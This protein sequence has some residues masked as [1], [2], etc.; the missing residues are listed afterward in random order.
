[1]R[2]FSKMERWKFEEIE[3]LYIVFHFQ[4]S[5]LPD[6][7]NFRYTFSKIAMTNPFISG[8]RLTFSAEYWTPPYYMRHNIYDNRYLIRHSKF[9]L[10]HDSASPILKTRKYFR[11][12]TLYK[13]F[14]NLARNKAPTTEGQA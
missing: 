3:F 5:I 9:F 8:N 1:M 13:Q 14:H 12:I 2:F 6:R 7:C 4:S 11:I 10:F